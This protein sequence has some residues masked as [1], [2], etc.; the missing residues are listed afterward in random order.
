MWC[1]LQRASF[2]PPSSGKSDELEKGEVAAL[3]F[4]GPLSSGESAHQLSAV[5]SA[6]RVRFGDLG[7]SLELGELIGKGGEPGRPS[8]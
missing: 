7:Q 2:E 6:L 8:C 1:L 3:A 4:A 5:A